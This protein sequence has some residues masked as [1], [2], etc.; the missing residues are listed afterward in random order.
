MKLK[1]K[2]ITIGNDIYIL[3]RLDNSKSSELY[4]CQCCDCRIRTPNTAS[5]LA[6]KYGKDYCTPYTYFKKL[7]QGV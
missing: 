6:Y 7:T 1:D 4:S 5:C 3:Q 2:I